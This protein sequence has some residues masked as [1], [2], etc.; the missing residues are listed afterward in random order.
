[1]NRPL[2]YL[3]VLVAAIA[4]FAIGALWFSPL[5]FAKP[6]M[7]AVGISEASAQGRS[8]MGFILVSA[9]VCELIMAFALAVFLRAANIRGAAAGLIAGFLVA[10]GLIVMAIGTNYLFEGKSIGLFGIV[11]GHVC[12]T[13]AAMGAILGGWQKR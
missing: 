9:F 6:W 7:R 4:N 11:A 1:M 3:A 5:L 12:V 10:L 13:C 8:G 2:N